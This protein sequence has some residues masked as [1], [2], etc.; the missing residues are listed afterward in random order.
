M[1]NAQVYD[2]K[3]SKWSIY[4]KMNQFIDQKWSNLDILAVFDDVWW[5]SRKSGIMHYIMKLIKIY[6]FL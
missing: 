5:L 6:T 1:L 2:N 3:S 4:S